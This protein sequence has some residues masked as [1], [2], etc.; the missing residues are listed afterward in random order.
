[1]RVESHCPCRRRRT[2]ACAVNPSTAGY[3][4]LAMYSDHGNKSVRALLRGSESVK[5]RA[6]TTRVAVRATSI[7]VLDYV[8]LVVLSSVG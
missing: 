1:M 3:P 2:R 8:L 7:M 4:E 6:E 5:V